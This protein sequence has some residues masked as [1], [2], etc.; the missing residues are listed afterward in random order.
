MEFNV[1]ENKIPKQLED[2]RKIFKT[3]PKRELLS[4]REGIDY[5]ITLKTKEIKS[6]L[7]IPTRLEEQQIVKEYLDEMIR[8]EQIRSNKSLIAALLFLVL[9]SRLEKKR[10]V[11]DYRKLNEEIVTDSTLLLL[12]R[13]IIDQMEGQ[14]YFI[15]IDLKDAFNQ[16]KI[17]KGDEQKTAFRIR[18]KT[19][20]YLVMSFGL[21]NAP[22]TFQRFI[23]QVL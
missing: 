8:K 6:L 23:N 12:I 21:I 13:D 2:L 17:K 10:P 3:V 4:S 22:V 20:K 18:Y 1:I 9:K 16:I 15:K 5:K 14:N 7:L 11:I 19:F